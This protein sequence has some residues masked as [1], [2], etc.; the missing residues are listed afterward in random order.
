ST[1]W[2]TGLVLA[3]YLDHQT[4]L[5]N[6]DLSGKTV[7]ELGSGTGIVGI[8]LGRLHPQCQ[9]IL[10]DKKELIPLLSRNIELNSA[11]SNT[12]AQCLDWTLPTALDV[13]PDLIVVSDG[14]WDKDLHQ[15][16]AETLARLAGSETRVLLAYETRKFDEEAEF[17]AKW[18]QTFRFRDIKPSEQ[19]PLAEV[20]RIPILGTESIV[21]GFHLVDYIWTDIFSNLPAASTYV[22]ITDSNLAKLYLSQYQE[23]FQVAWAHHKPASAA[24]RL[25]THVLPPG[26][27]SKSRATKSAIEDWMFGE[28]CT[29]DTTV[30]A[31]GGGVIGDL[32]GYVAATFMR[33]VSFIQIPTSLLAMVDSSIGGKTAVDTPAG[34]NLV[35]SFWQPK[36]IYMDMA[37]LSTLPQREFS[38]GMAEV[39]KTAAIW[40]S[41]EFDVLESSSVEIRRAVLSGTRDG[42]AGL[43][44]ATRSAEQTLLQRVIAASARVKAYVVTHDE[45]ESGMRGLLNFGHTIGHAIEAILSPQVLHGECVAVGC[46][47]EAEVAR[48]MG[49]LSE[50]GVARLVRC[51]RAYGLPTTMDDPLL[52]AL[53]SSEQLAEVRPQRLMDIMGVDKKTVGTQK[54]LVV[55]K[56]LGATL[57]LKPTNV[58]DALILE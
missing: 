19:D 25:L 15:P 33:G 3:K 47:L 53:A 39:I 14:I 6:L 5:G 43:T 57:E 2:D 20:E 1:V 52:R 35:G 18:S 34:K 42:D 56:Q 45:R 30:L 58:S 28:K 49:H 40:D 48:R 4:S 16:L 51:L 36:R 41:A 21:C 23:S 44:L 24:P 26:E 32:V 46:V 50:V 31:L 12:R 54:R 8:A 22:L 29:R 37:V 13:V 55:L 11:M 27:L 17:I 7:L 38:N 9:V 10:T